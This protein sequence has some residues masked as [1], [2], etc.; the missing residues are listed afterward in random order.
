MLRFFLLLLAI[1]FTVI[2]FPYVQEKILLLAYASF[3]N[4]SKKS[5]LSLTC[6]YGIFP[7]LIRVSRLSYL[8]PNHQK[9]DLKDLDIM[10]VPFDGV[11]VNSSNFSINTN[12]PLKKNWYYKTY[13]L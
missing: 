4:S 3:E 6:D 7:F 5:S 9:F 11:Y 8:T 12:T 13:N 1:V 2:Q 10:Y